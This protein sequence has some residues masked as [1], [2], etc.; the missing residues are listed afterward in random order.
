MTK[1]LLFLGFVVNGDGIQVY[2]EKIKAIWEWLT[3][4]T[5][6]EVRNFHGLETFYRH[7]STNVVPIIDCLKKVKFHWGE[8]VETTFVILKEKL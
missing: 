2:E 5:V 4:K 7:F 8:K 1:K 3:P 6:T